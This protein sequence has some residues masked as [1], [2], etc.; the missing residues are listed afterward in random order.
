MLWRELPCQINT[1]I[2]FFSS[3]II[4][5]SSFV[6]YS[7]Y[8]KKQTINMCDNNVD[9]YDKIDDKYDLYSKINDKESLN[10]KP[11]EILNQE[12][13]KLKFQNS[14]KNTIKTFRANNSIYRLFGYASLLVG[15][16]Y[17][18]NNQLLSLIPYLV[19]F[20]IAPISV[21]LFKIKQQILNNIM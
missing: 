4:T 3:L 13:K 19:G 7:K 21:L 12:K 18:N 20:A 16:F 1:Q 10:K 9:I 8:I 6:G 5:F 14:I 17:L 15:F 11:E 2:A